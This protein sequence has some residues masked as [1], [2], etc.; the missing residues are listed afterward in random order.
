MDNL[1]ELTLIH[2]GVGHDD[3][4]LRHQQRELLG[5]LFNIRNAIVDVEDLALTQQLT[6]NRLNNG[7]LVVLSN[8]GE[9]RLAVG[10]W[11]RHH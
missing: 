11:G 2:L 4:G 6:T 10:R 8:V 5:D 9:N 1:F 7:P 3:A